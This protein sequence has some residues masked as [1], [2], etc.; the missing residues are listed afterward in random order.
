MTGIYSCGLI[1]FGILGATNFS[2]KFD[3][4]FNYLVSLYRE[5]AI[6]IDTISKTAY[7]T[8]KSD[9]ANI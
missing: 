6:V 9:L 5:K 3:M 1:G 4:E 8:T 7:W 2:K